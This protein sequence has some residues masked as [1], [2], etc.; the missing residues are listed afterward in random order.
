MEKKCDFF[1]FGC[2][3]TTPNCQNLSVSQ[4]KCKK[5]IQIYKKGDFS[6]EPPIVLKF[7]LTNYYLICTNDLK[8]S[9]RYRVHT[10]IYGKV[11]SSS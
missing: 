11:I 10:Y 3:I 8:Y 2:K 9:N 6:I 5:N 7:Y 1:D 4:K